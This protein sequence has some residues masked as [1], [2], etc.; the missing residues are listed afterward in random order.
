[1]AAVTVAVSKGDHSLT[2]IKAVFVT[3]LD[4]QRSKDGCNT[5]N[6]CLLGL[7]AFNEGCKQCRCN[8]CGLGLL[9]VLYTDMYGSV[10]G[11][12]TVGRCVSP[13]TLFYFCTQLYLLK[14]GLCKTSATAG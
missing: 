5:K 13:S 3:S 14:D 12:V 7:L 1:M 2:G 10:S 6:T 4:G 11:H 8:L 9:S